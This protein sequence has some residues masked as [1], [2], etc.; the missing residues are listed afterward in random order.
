MNIFWADDYTFRANR[1]QRPIRIVTVWKQH[2]LAGFFGG[3]RDL[4]APDLSLSQLER[5]SP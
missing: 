2:M 1:I 3:F 4:L 5:T